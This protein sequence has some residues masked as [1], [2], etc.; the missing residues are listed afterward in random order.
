MRNEKQDRIR[1]YNITILFSILH[2]HINLFTVENVLNPSFW[3]AF[4]A[5]NFPIGNGISDIIAEIIIVGI[6][7]CVTSCIAHLFLKWNNKNKWLVG[8]VVSVCSY[9]FLRQFVH[10]NDN[11]A[12]YKLYLDT[13][14]Y[15]ALKLAIIFSLT[16]LIYV[17]TYYI[18]SKGL[19]FDFQ[20]IK[21]KWKN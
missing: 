6:Q 13:Y 7:C 4:I 20:T 17:F 2:V 1:R 15:S 8:Y 3:V 9:L 10:V 12:L 18:E 5:A 19:A 11:T 16:Q 14:H 21:K